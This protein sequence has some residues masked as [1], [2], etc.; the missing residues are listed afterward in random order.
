MADAVLR[1]EERL[2]STAVAGHPRCAVAFPRDRHVHPISTS[3][4]AS[5]GAAVDD[6]PWA[7]LGASRPDRVPQK[8]KRHS[9]AVSKR[10]VVDTRF[11]GRC[12]LST[13]RGEAYDPGVDV[14]LW[15]LVLMV[16]L[17]GL[18]LPL[19]YEAGC[20]RGR[21]SAVRDGSGPPEP[22][23]GRVLALHRVVEGEG[24]TEPPP[25]KGA[26]GSQRPSRRSVRSAIAH[27]LIPE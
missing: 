17:I 27:L 23:A 18:V 1:A 25:N 19:V 14:D 15:L 26:S 3:V 22:E 16:V 7:N 8:G 4:E 24:H 2:Q 9:G 6:R 20:K 13:V 11:H 10:V 5:A 12:G 21:A